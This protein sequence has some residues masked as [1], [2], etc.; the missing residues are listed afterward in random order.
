MRGGPGIGRS[1]ILLVP[2]HHRLLR[3]VCAPTSLAPFHSLQEIWEANEELRVRSA[4]GY[5]QACRT[6][7]HPSRDVDD[8]A[9]EE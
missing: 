8:Q 9:H 1:S 5:T 4:P 7:D 2:G 3:K 6:L